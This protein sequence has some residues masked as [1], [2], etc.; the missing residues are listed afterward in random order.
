MMGAFVVCDLSKM[1]KTE[2]IG[3]NIEYFSSEHE[4][5]TKLYETVRQSDPDI[6]VGFELHRNSWGYIIQRGF[7]YNIDLSR[8]LSRIAANTQ[9]N[10]KINEYFDKKQSSLVTTGR[11]FLNIWRLLRSEL[12]LTS[13]TF[14]NI[15]FHVCH[16]RV[17]RYSYDTLSGW[18]LRGGPFTC[19]VFRHMFNSVR[20]N[21]DILSRT[22]IISRTSEFARVFGIDFMSVITRG[23]QFKVESIMCRVARPENFIMISPSRMQVA[24]QRA[25]ECIPLVMEPMSNFYSS[26]LLV[27]DFQSLY[28]SV[29]IAYNYCYSTCLGRAKKIG[30]PSKFGILDDF[31]VPLE[32]VQKF[33]DHLNVSPNG[34]VFVK[35]HIRQGVIPRM[36]SEIL[37]TR[38]ML[39]Q[40][41]KHYKDEKYLYRILDARQLGMKFIANV[42]Y[43]YTGASFSGRMPSSEIADAIVQTGRATLERCIDMIHN[44][45]E[46][47]AKV[48]YGDTDSL[49][50]YLPGRT[51]ASAFRIGKEIVDHMTQKNPYPVKLKFEKVYHPSV[52]LT[53]KRYVGNMFETEGQ[54]VGVFDAKGIETVR[55]DNCP[56]VG[57][58]LKA[59]LLEL[60]HT[61]DMSRLKKF[62]TKQ[63]SDI[64]TGQVSVMDLIIAK[65]VKWGSYSSVGVPPPGVMVALKKLQNDVQ[66]EPQYGERIPYVVVDRGPGYRLVDCVMDP[67]AF[68]RSSL[69]IHS[70]YYITKQIIPA[71]NRVFN[72]V[73]IDIMQWFN[74][75]PKPSTFTSIVSSGYQIKQLTF[76]IHTKG[77]AAPSTLDHILD[78]CRACS[79]Q[80]TMLG[81]RQPSQQL[82]GG[83]ESCASLDCPYFYLKQKALSVYGF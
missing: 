2:M 29:M 49:F 36:L 46:W 44:T 51:K 74:E 13:Y 7:Q 21:L 57:K 37:E 55:R 41:M 56:I 77:G 47:K 65:E 24:Q 76:G 20:L 11:H 83:A 12:A 40:S 58:T 6:L 53:K 15:V 25:I 19:R 38:V 59:S 1:T 32:V 42:T 70:K 30:E 72:I 22:Q 4:I 18:F 69:Q 48:V 63:F 45:S 73:G 35:P 33:K 39:K 52:L 81:I 66:A 64:M 17:P 62:L 43:G 5:I 23:S 68:M 79:G 82:L 16:T 14:E 3:Y 80:P 61:Q 26:P 10:I 78:V 34:M 60:F 31:E 67:E 50:V 71:L 9:K 75:M 8:E 28:P 54:T 27:L